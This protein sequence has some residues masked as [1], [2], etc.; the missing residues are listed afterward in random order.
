VSTT[1][2][3]LGERAGNAAL[4]EVVMAMRHLY[5]VESGVDGLA[6]AGISALVARASGRPVAQNKSIVGEAVFTHE[7]G[8]HVDGLLKDPRNYQGFDPAELGRH[9]TLVLGKHSGSHAVIAAYAQLGLTLEATEV[10]ALLER[11]RAHAGHQ[12]PARER[13]SAA[14][15]RR[16][17]A[18]G[19]PHPLPPHHPATRLAA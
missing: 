14:L 13:R 8:I 17:G 9:H 2:N 5:G 15:S 19:R 6:L 3:G 18:R 16:S 7:S 12:A 11:I 10:P 4:E 1:V